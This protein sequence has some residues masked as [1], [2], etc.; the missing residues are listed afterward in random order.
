MNANDVNAIIDNICNKLG[1]TVEMVVPEYA[2]YMIA[3]KLV[4][5][6]IGVMI[7][8]FA[9]ALMN[10]MLTSLKKEIAEY[11][12]KYERDDWW[13]E[14]WVFPYILGGIA[15]IFVGIVGTATLVNGLDFIPWLI[16]PQG[17]FI[18]EVMK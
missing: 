12:E 18:A 14:D 8:F 16:S 5:L 2:K 9:T 17:A 10:M 3:S 4:T 15:L 11:K 6:I 1:T 13:S 7:T